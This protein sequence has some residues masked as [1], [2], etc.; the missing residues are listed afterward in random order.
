MSVAYRLCPKCLR[1]V[2]L[3]VNERFCIQCGTPMTT[4]CPRCQAP[5]TSPYA[6]FC[7][8]CGLEYRQQHRRVTPG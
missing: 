3:A 6:R 4:A 1:G 7:G 5:I 8:G 2:P